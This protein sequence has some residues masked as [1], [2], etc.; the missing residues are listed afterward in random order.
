M[1]FDVKIVISKIEFE[2]KN[3]NCR[4][5]DATWLLYNI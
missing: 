2:I 4:K 5:W 3:D 1:N